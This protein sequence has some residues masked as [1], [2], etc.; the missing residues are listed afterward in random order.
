MA[1]T[2]VVAVPSVP[3][4]ARSTAPLPPSCAPRRPAPLSGA[5]FD[6]ASVALFARLRAARAADEPPPERSRKARAQS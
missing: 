2:R 3:D 5:A 6:A 1:D 4:A